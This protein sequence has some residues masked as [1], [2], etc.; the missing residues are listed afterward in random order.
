MAVT[1]P[2]FRMSE[3]TEAMTVS[4]SPVVVKTSVRWCRLSDSRCA[5]TS[6]QKMLFDALPILPP[7][8]IAVELSAPVGVLVSVALAPLTLLA[9]FVAA[10]PG[11]QMRCCSVPAVFVMRRVKLCSFWPAFSES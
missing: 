5:G 11:V 1:D 3:I 4:G 6:N 7:A 8:A 2:A 9:K 10:P